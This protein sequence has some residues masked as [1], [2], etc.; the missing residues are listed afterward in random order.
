M[1]FKP[2]IF[3]KHTESR[4]VF[5]VDPCSYRKMYLSWT[6]ERSYK[7]WPESHETCCIC[8]NIFPVYQNVYLQQ[9]DWLWMHH[10]EVARQIGMLRWW[11]W[12]YMN[13]VHVRFSLYWVMPPCPGSR[14]SF[15]E[16]TLQ[17]VTF[18]LGQI[19]TFTL[20]AAIL[21]SVISQRKLL[22]RFS[23]G[24]ENVF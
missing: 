19:C 9:V 4:K 5:T 6:M 2:W 11:Q 1:V 24:C 16:S 7:A 15:S 21:T 20:S 18:I 17:P 8:K 12:S 14:N 13:A 23:Y 3:L 22:S 10:L